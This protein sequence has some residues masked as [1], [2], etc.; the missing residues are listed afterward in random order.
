MNPE[1]LKS[2]G[3]S[4]K[5]IEIIEDTDTNYPSDITQINTEL[6][7][8]NYLDMDNIIVEKSQEPQNLIYNT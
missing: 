2:L 8:S 7:T 3:F 4:K 1:L 6:E 5:F